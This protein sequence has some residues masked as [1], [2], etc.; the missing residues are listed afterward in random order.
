MINASVLF[1]HK[2][3][4]CHML[5]VCVYVCVCIMSMSLNATHVRLND[6]YD[7]YALYVLGSWKCLP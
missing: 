6:D 7:V 1:D 5:C 2:L 3:D 4:G